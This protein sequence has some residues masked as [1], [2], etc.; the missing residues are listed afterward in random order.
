MLLDTNIVSAFLRRDGQ[1]QAPRLFEFIATVLSAEG[2]AISY[3]TQFELR[4]G[5]E[6]LVRRGEGRRKLVAFEKFMERVQVLGLDGASGEGWNLAA[7]LWS[8]GRSLKPALVLTDA[9]LLIAATAASHGHEFATSEVGL[10]EGLRR[11]AT[12]P[13]AVRLVPME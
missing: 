3:V 9:D 2:L 11:L 10:V 13:V 12:F 1:K 8:E 7:R 5:I 6:E 4:R